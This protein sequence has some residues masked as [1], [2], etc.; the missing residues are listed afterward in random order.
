[1]FTHRKINETNERGAL[2]LEAIALLGLMTMMS[3]MVV[4][5]TADRTAEMQEVTVAGQMKELKDALNNWIEANYR[6]EAAKIETSQLEKRIPITAAHLAPYLPSAALDNG[7]FRGNKLVDGFDI[8][9]FAQCIEMRYT[10]GSECTVPDCYTL[11]NGAVTAGTTINSSKMCSRYKMTGIILSNGPEI[12]DRR[13]VR[14]ATMVGADGGYTRTA[15]VLD[16]LGEA[17]DSPER[18]K[19]LGSQGIWEGQTNTYFDNLSNTTGRIAV[20]TSFSSGLSGDYLYRKKVDGLPDANSMF[21]DLDMGGNTQCNGNACNKINNAG[22]LEVIGGRILIRSQNSAAGSD[23]EIGNPSDDTYAKIALGADRAHM[24]VDNDLS[25][26]A[27]NNAFLNMASNQV[28]L[29]AGS[30]SRLNMTSTAINMSS[31]AVDVI[32]N[33]SVN[34]NVNDTSKISMGSNQMSFS[35]N[36]GNPN[37]I[38]LNDSAIGMLI[39]N[40]TNASLTLNSTEAKTSVGS[41]YSSL[42]QSLAKTYLSSDVYQSLSKTDKEIR[43]KVGKSETYL[44]ETETKTLIK[45]GGGSDASFSL[46]NQTASQISVNGGTASSLL[47]QTEA[48][49]FVNNGRVSAFSLKPSSFDLSFE[50][51]AN[52]HKRFVFTPEHGLKMYKRASSAYEN[53]VEDDNYAATI[54][55]NAESGR[56][57]A[58][59]FQPGKK[60]LTN[61]NTWGNIVQSRARIRVNEETGLTTANI[62][63]VSDGADASV[64]IDFNA[65]SEGLQAPYKFHKDTDGK[66]NRFRVDPAFTSV[67]N[68]IKITSRGGA[69]LSEALP[70]YILKGIYILSNSYSA[71]G[72][73][74]TNNTTTGNTCAFYMP[75]YDPDD[76]GYGVGFGNAAEF[77]CGQGSDGHPVL[78]GGGSCTGNKVAG[79]VKFDLSRNNSHIYDTEEYKECPEDASKTCWAHPFMGKI[80]A[81]GRSVTTTI[82]GGTNQVL[83]AQDE[84]VCPDGYQAVM[85]ITPNSFELG[86]IIALN[87]DAAMAGNAILRYNFGYLNFQESAYRDVTSIIQASTRLG[88]STEAIISQDGQI[89]GWRVAM[90]TVTP[91]GNTDADY[92]WNFGGVPI[93]SWSAIAH[94][95]CYFNPERFTMPNMRFMKETLA[96]GSANYYITPASAGDNNVI[97]TPMD[98]PLLDSMNGAFD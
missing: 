74:C 48:R 9:V 69:R 67:M 36:T 15:K 61:E 19:I 56:V 81:P 46:M 80:P 64:T 51:A 50:E 42:Q 75:W 34:L 14:I 88:V 83:H 38:N 70:N 43:T 62:E 87:T 98:N 12:E 77:N 68:D 94:T 10:N 97:L 63:G 47:N 91:S 27:A 20:T 3:P 44:N 82:N 31:N 7:A 28:N 49:T 65:A 13:A 21:T 8:S 30:K 93:N 96:Q 89:V 92:I 29:G 2:M 35:I 4:R 58:G 37:I 39:N 85:T 25:F 59:F 66:Y 16:A 55:L 90:G 40:G 54:Q 60:I 24:H 26:V 6:T 79:Y 72:W 71:G 17:N 57:S 84:G 41:A 33:N 52:Q 5:Q 53:I 22:G 95:Y 45:D 18:K 23:Q 76:L 32:A 78:Y 73:P 86:R 1:M 11:T